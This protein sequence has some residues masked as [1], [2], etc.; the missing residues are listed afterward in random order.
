MSVYR[1]ITT[2]RFTEIKALVDGLKLVVDC[3]I[4]PIEIELDSIEAIEALE[5]SQPIYMRKINH[6]R[7][8]M[9]RLGNPPIRH[10][11]RQA[12][13]VA[14]FLSRPGTK[15]TPS[16]QA[17]ILSAPPDHAMSL[18]KDDQQRAISTKLVLRTTCN[19]LAGFGNLTVLANYGNNAEK[20]MPKNLVTL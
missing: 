9:K 4:V 19:K 7:L 2:Q 8:L 12:N 14:D 20:E 3:C 11:F 16:E 17:T 13:K 15:L 18:V 1:N 6:S 10:S 5:N